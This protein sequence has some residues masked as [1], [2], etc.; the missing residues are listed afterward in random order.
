VV[1]GCPALKMFDVAT[2]HAGQGPRLNGMRNNLEGPF[3]RWSAQPQV[4][5]SPMGKNRPK[6]LDRPGFGL[7]AFGASFLQ[8]SKQYLCE[9]LAIFYTPEAPGQQ[10]T[11]QL[12]SYFRLP[13]LICSARSH[14][15]RAR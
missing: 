11:K 7:W 8:D 3:W 9:W 14:R 1:R 13:Q 12:Q 10:S 2:V 15:F 5:G 4:K 6:F